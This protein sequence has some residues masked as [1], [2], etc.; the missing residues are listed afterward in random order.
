MKEAKTHYRSFGGVTLTDNNGYQY[1]FK[2]VRDAEAKITAHVC[3]LNNSSISRACNRG[4]AFKH[5]NRRG[6]HQAQLDGCRFRWGTPE[7]YDP[8]TLPVE[9]VWPR[10]LLPLSAATDVPQ[11]TTEP[12]RALRATT[13]CTSSNEVTCFEL[14]YRQHGGNSC[15]NT[16]CDYNSEA[17]N[18]GCSLTNILS[19]IENDETTWSSFKDA[20]G[21]KHYYTTH[22]VKVRDIIPIMKCG[23]GTVLAR[24]E[25][26]F[27]K[28]RDHVMTTN[29]QLW[30]DATL[31]GDER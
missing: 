4:K 23:Q 27:E 9:P 25:R 13:A 24:E 8:Q 15:G 14:L 16:A 18:Q 12:P 17:A 20:D 7:P 1:H 26:A 29:A 2:S 31:P 3:K 5:D 10:L 21:E 6:R 22:G 19:N 30:Q 28:I 11:K